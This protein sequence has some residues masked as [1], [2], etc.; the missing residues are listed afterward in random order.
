MKMFYP[1]NALVPAEK[2]TARFVLRP[3]QA[4]H[5]ELDYEA[6]MASAEYLHLWSQSTWPA[7]DFTLAEDLADLQRHEREHLQREA[8]TY[9]VLNL[10]GTQC[11]GCVYI[12]PL[13]P[14]AADLC[15]ESDF[16]AA[17]GFWTRTSASPNDLDRYLL[18]T[19]R[20]WFRAEWAFDCIV[21]TFNPR[22]E[23]QAVLF[24]QAEPRL[25]YKSPEGV[26]WMAVG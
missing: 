2:R 20:T 18:D 24:E 13:W 14:W 21:F 8:F 17:V 16:A 10:A 22:D 6:V 15:A 23:R 25:R 5:V 7:E 3:L 12:Q 1:P 26:S 9:T 19:L 11:L 4:I